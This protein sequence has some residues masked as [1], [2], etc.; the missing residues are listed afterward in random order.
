EISRG[1]AVDA[2]GNAYVMGSTCSTN[3]PTSASAFQKVFAGGSCG[4]GGGAGEGDIF[5][6]KLNAAGSALL[7]ATYFGGSNEEQGTDVAI[8]LAGNA[9]IT[10]L[11]HS[12]DLPV[13]QPLQAAHGGGTWDAFVA[14][15]NPDGSDVL[16][17]TYLGGVGD[18]QGNS[19]AVDLAGNAYVIG[20][21]GSPNF[22]KMSPLQA[23]PAGR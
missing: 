9:S 13:R 20:S 21:T 16:Y 22:P 19:I 5:V 7:Y 14:K 4:V 12:N 2:S 11:T 1:L 17:A 8:D 23:S 3:F 10:G 6:A 15:L 18:D